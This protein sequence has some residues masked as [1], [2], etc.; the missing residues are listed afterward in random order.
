MAN[1]TGILQ[2]LETARGKLQKELSSIDSAI[3]ALQGSNSRRG[4]S[5]NTTRPR[6]FMSVAAR[7]RIAAAQR[8]RWAKWKAAKK[9]AA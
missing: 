8:V 5:A 1:L 3:A 2:E 7:R 9:K 4:A 6:R